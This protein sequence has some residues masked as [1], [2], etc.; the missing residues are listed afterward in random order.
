MTV[1]STQRH[2]DIQGASIQ[3]GDA[4]SLLHHIA[5]DVRDF[6]F[7]E[8]PKVGCVV[9][10]AHILPDDGH[11]IFFVDNPADSFGSNGDYAVQPLSGQNVYQKV[12]GH[13]TPYNPPSGGLD[14]TYQAWKVVATPYI[15]DSITHTAA[16]MAVFGSYAGVSLTFWFD[17][18]ADVSVT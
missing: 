16:R 18:V 7:S 4:P 14:C 15:G 12:A 2:I 13:W 8:K 6:G 10:Q 1:F 9:L 5:F 11:A 17:H 3:L